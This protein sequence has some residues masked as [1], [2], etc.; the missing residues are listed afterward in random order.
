MKFETLSE[1]WKKF[2]TIQQEKIFSKTKE[3]ISNLKSGSYCWLDEKVKV[4]TTSLMVPLHLHIL[5]VV[6]PG[7]DNQRPDTAAGSGAD[8][9]CRAS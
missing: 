4:T 9:V 3:R 6:W 5:P 8:T 2:K 7:S 1:I